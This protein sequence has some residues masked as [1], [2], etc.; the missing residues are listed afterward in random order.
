MHA[1][2]VAK[3]C[4]T[5]LTPR[6]P[7]F[8]GFPREEYWKGLPFPSPGDLP[9]PGVKHAPLAWQVDYL[10]LSHVGSVLLNILTSF[11]KWFFSCV[12]GS[13]YGSWLKWS[14]RG[15]SFP[16]RT[17]GA[18][19]GQSRELGAGE[20]VAQP[21]S[22]FPVSRLASVV[23]PPIPPL[24][25]KPCLTLTPKIKLLGAADDCNIAIICN[26]ASPSRWAN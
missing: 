13:N 24:E 4:P 3:S 14:S 16:V 18:A 20:P 1:Y 5:L 25:K 12:H 6:I 23:F 22:T 15:C 19:V 21:Q 7:L 9:H 2:S 11:K 10:P 8:M 26:P 17:L